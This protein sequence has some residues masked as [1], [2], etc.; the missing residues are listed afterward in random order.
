MIRWRHYPLHPEQ[1]TIT[2][3]LT[4]LADPP[5]GLQGIRCRAS[6]MG[7][8]NLADICDLAGRPDFVDRPVTITRSIEQRLRARVSSSVTEELFGTGKLAHPHLGLRRRQQSDEM[9]NGGPRGQ[10]KKCG[11]K[12]Q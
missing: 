5:R 11:R 2:S 6:A 1:R 8:E 3:A 12:G 9:T 4:A 10:Y 7:L